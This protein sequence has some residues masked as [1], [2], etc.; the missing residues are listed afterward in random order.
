MLLQNRVNFAPFRDMNI[1][2]ISTHKV[3][4]DDPLLNQHESSYLSFS[5]LPEGGYFLRHLLS[6]IFMQAHPLDG[7]VLYV[8]RTFLFQ[9]A[10]SDRAVY[11]AKI[12]NLKIWFIMIFV[13]IMF[14]CLSNIYFAQ[15]LPFLNPSHA[16]SDGL[17]ILTFDIEWEYYHIF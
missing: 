14:S 11:A 1:H 6:Y 10:E 8:V 3:Y 13:F 17:L 7:V 4:P 15:N 5:P 16:E 9:H 2:G 12:G